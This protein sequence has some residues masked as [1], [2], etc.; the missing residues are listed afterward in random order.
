MVRDHPFGLGLRNYEVAYNQYDWSD[1]RYGLSMNVHSTYLQVLAELGY[2]GAI[3]Y[4]NLLWYCSRACLKLR[5]HEDAGVVQLA[6]GLLASMGAFMVGSA[7][8]AQFLIDLNWYTFA[9]IAALS[10][11]VREPERSA[12]RKLA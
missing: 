8:G 6:N 4:A 2:V 5:R 11:S 12:E 3:L 1:G 9:L 7:F 10:R